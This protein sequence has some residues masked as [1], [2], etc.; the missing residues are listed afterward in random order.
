MK[1]KDED[2]NAKLHN[3]RASAHYHLGKVSFR[4]ISR[5]VS[6]ASSTVSTTELEDNG[7]VILFCYSALCCLFCV[8]T[9]YILTHNICTQYPRL[10]EDSA[11]SYLRVRE[12]L[13]YELLKAVCPETSL[14]NSKLLLIFQN[15]A[16]LP[17]RPQ[18]FRPESPLPLPQSLHL[19]MYVD[20]WPKMSSTSSSFSGNYH[21]CLGNI[22]AATA[23]QP[24]YLKAI[25]RGENKRNLKI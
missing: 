10:K 8:E 5:I 2:L 21:D 20:V 15:V 25:I 7:P 6:I 19:L 18:P 12:R 16:F 3:N 23:L 11:R 24:F 1:C 13:R 9:F 22:K 17:G 14:S 4:F